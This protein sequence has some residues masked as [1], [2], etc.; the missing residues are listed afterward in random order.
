MSKNKFRTAGLWL[1]A[2]VLAAGLLYSAHSFQ[3]A[4]RRIKSISRKQNDLKELFALQEVALVEM[5]AVRKYEEMA[6]GRPCSLKDLAGS[7][8]A[9]IRQRENLSLAGGWILHRT[10]VVFSEIPFEAA[11]RFVKSAGECR[12]PWRVTECL[13]AASQR[14]EQAGTV[15]LILEAL[16]KTGGGK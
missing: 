3:T 8:R 2:A 9:D 6:S 7:H 13:F 5:A 15:T 16:E 11:G 10:E 4:P 1:A 14:A 12:P